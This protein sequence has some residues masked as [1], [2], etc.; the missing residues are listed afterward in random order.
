MTVVV[1]RRSDVVVC[2][3]EAVVRVT[4][5]LVVGWAAVNNANAYANV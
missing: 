2:V 1:R 4:V 3:Y 5:V